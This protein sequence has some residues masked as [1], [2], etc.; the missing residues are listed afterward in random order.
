MV[1]PSIPP[2]LSP[3]HCVE[4]GIN[5]LTGLVL[6]VPISLLKLTLELFALTIDYVEVVIRE[7]TP[8]LLDLTFD[9]FPVS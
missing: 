7:S 1:V 4:P 3:V 2:S 6:G 8:L 5:V 9:L